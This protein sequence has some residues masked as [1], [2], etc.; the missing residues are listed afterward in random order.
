MLVIEQNIYRVLNRDGKY[1]SIIGNC[2]FCHQ[3]PEQLRIG[4]RKTNNRLLAKFNGWEEIKKGQTMAENSNLI[5]IRVHLAKIG[6]TETV[7]EG[8]YTLNILRKS[9]LPSVKRITGL[10]SLLLSR[11]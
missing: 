4:N 3:I 7:D 6:Y 8:V 2:S 10:C 5:P 1:I 9:G 11:G